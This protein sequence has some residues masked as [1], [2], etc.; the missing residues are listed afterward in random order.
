MVV[1]AAHEKPCEPVI[2]LNVVSSI[3]H[4]HEPVIR[5]GISL[6]RHWEFGLGIGMR[7]KQNSQ[8]KNAGRHY[9][10]NKSSNSLPPADIEYHFREKDQVKEKECLK[11]EQLHILPG[12]DVDQLPDCFLL[13]E[14]ISKIPCDHPVEQE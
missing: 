10:H 7:G 12:R 6:I 4:V 13:V 11:Y 8:C 1:E 14:K 9:H 2:F 3:Q 5:Q